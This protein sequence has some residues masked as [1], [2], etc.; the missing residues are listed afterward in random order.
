MEPTSFL[1]KLPVKTDAISRSL[2]RVARIVLGIGI[3]ASLL[4]FIPGA[5]G[6]L[7]PS[8]VYFLLAA[9]LVVVVCT[10]LAILRSGAFR[11]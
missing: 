6:L 3:V 2:M 9:I 1:P 11:C 4:L 8:K 5:P 10:S 7:G